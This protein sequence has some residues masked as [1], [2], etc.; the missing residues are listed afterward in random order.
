[1]I[2]AA[3]SRRH[4]CQLSHRGNHEHHEQPDCDHGVDDARG[5]A[6]EQAEVAGQQGVFPSRLQDR[7]EAD[8]A[9]ELEV[10]L[11]L[12]SKGFAPFGAMG[13]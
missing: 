3:G 6:I 1:V 11:R 8:D 2:L 10:A 13:A 4:G 9:D 12:I 5:A 7:N